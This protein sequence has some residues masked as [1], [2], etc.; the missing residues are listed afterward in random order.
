VSLVPLA[1]NRIYTQVAGPDVFYE[2]V[3]GPQN[4]FAITVTPSAGYD[5]SIYLL[6]RQCG[7]GSACAAGHGADDN[8]EGVAETL[9][10]SGLATGTYYLGID[11]FY[12]ST[13]ARSSGTYSVS[14]TGTLAVIDDDGGAGDATTGDDAATGDDAEGDDA[15]TEDAETDA[16]SGDDGGTLDSGAHRDAGASSHADA[17]HHHDGGEEEGGDASN[18]DGGSSSGAA[19]SGG[20]GCRVMGARQADRGPFVAMGTLGLALAFGRRRRVR[21]RAL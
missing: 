21:R 15:A 8:P 13:D 16:E 11:S 4:D 6:T 5:T 3:V 20:C 1:C 10:L 9:K 7:V 18:D 17:G 12:P 2:L 19:A 14:V